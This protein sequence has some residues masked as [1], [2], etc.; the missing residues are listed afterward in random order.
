MPALLYFARLFFLF[1]V[2]GGKI[3][4]FFVSGFYCFGNCSY[5]Y[6]RYRKVFTF[7]S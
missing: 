7:C 1:V 3:K 4:D 5:G 2:A 6:N